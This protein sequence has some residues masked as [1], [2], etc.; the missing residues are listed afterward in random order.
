[1]DQ[2]TYTHETP[3]RLTVVG[4]GSSKYLA[5]IPNPLPPLLKLDADTLLLL[6]HADQSLGRLAGIGRFAKHVALLVKPLVRREAVLS[7]H[8]E[9]TQSGL[10]DLYRYEADHLPFPPRNGSSGD[11]DAHE[12]YNY[13]IALEYGLSR[14]ASLPVSTRLIRELHRRLMK[15]VRGDQAT[16]GELRTTQ[17]WIGPPGCTLNE[18]TYVPPPVDAMTEALGDLEKYIHETPEVPQ[19]IRLALVHYQFE[20]IHPFVDGNGRVGRLL[21][22][23]LAVEWNLLPSPLLYLSAYFDRNRDTYYRLLLGVSTHGDWLTWIQFFLSAVISESS[24]T[25][26]RLRSLQDLRDSWHV[27]LESQPRTSVLTLR[28]AD[29][30]IEQPFITVPAAAKLLGV[31]YRTAQLH[32]DRLLQARILKPRDARRYGKVYTAGDVLQIVNA[33]LQHIE[34]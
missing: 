6:S 31:T 19:L 11:D 14:L 25:L 8:I 21:L 5:Y 4:R 23:M 1:M 15:G 18:A 27:Q 26:R 24:D 22:A 20:A 7:S 30:L 28:L 13:V 12:V 9:G 16:P 17:N 10:D 34:S 32:V 29:A 2:T 3:G 33:L